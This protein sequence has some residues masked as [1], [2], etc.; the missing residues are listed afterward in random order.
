M[1]EEKTQKRKAFI[2][3][4]EKWADFA[5]KMQKDLDERVKKIK[6]RKSKTQTGLLTDQEKQ[7]CMKDYP[8]PNDVYLEGEYKTN[9][10]FIAKF[11]K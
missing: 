10:S 4:L 7:Q 9:D 5:K 8:A 11:I 6:R 2:E 1:A 3:R